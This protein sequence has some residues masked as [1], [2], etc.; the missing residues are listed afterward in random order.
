MS[1]S[2]EKNR[3]PK[4][5]RLYEGFKKWTSFYR[6][7]PHRFAEEYFGIRL[8]FFQK[9]MIFLMNHVNLWELIAARG[10][11]KSFLVALFAVIRCVLYPG[12]MIVI[13]SG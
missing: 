7:N 3:V 1:L 9:I 5:T 13:A 6:A 2:Q 4:E 12:T 8:Y 10:L 11:G